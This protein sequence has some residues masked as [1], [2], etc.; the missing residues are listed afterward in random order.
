M[1]CT[2]SSNLDDLSTRARWFMYMESNTRVDLAYVDLICWCQK[3]SRWAKI[4][5][6]NTMQGHISCFQFSNN[7]KLITYTP[8]LDTECP[9]MCSYNTYHCLNYHVRLDWHK[10]FKNM[11][12]KHSLLTLITTSNLPL[13]SS[14]W[15]EPKEATYTHLLY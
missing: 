13:Q 4:M 9:T 6:C 5:S 8:Y 10:S 7:I 15:L 2:T 12:Q 3:N 11:Q 14:I 1:N